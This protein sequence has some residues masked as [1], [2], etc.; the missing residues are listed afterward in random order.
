MTP[1]TSENLA[2][3]EQIVIAVHNNDQET[4]EDEPEVIATRK[5]T[6]EKRL[7]RKS[8]R[9]QRR[10]KEQKEKRKFFKKLAQPTPIDKS[11]LMSIRIDFPSVEKQELGKPR[12]K[13]VGGIQ[14]I[15]QCHNCDDIM[16]PQ[17]P[18]TI[19][20]E[21][22][23]IIPIDMPNQLEEARRNGRFFVDPRDPRYCS[24]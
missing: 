2:A 12:D 8:Q 9:N 3:K 21:G 1:G 7:E 4:S 10:H 15:K 18:R 20:I 23:R 5:S 17:P 14:E 22:Y 13:S 24:R 19:R 6:D 16:V 11:R